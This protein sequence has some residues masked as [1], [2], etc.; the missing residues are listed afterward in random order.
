VIKIGFTNLLM[1]RAQLQLS[2]IDELMQFFTPEFTHVGGL[3]MSQ[4]AI[5]LRQRLVVAGQ[6]AQRI[7]HRFQAIGE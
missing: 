3:Q 7:A 2:F 1:Q 6:A 5:A 4:Q